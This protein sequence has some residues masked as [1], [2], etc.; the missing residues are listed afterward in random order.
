MAFRHLFLAL[1]LPSLA[2]SCSPVANVT[3]VAN[4]TTTDVRGEIR[5]ATDLL[6]APDGDVV[7]LPDAP[8]NSD[9]SSDLIADARVDA[10]ADADLELA[11][12]PS[13]DQEQPDAVTEDVEL[14]DVFSLDQEQPDALTEDVES[15]DTTTDDLESNDLPCA[16]DCIGKDCGDDGCEGSCGECDDGFLCDAGQCVEVS[17]VPD[18]AGKQC[19]DDGCEDSCGDCPPGDIC[20]MGGCLPATCAGIQCGDDG[21]GNSCGECQ[22]YCV[23]GLCHEGAGCE[24]GGEPG[25][26]DCGCQDCVCANDEFCC[27]SSWDVVCVNH[28]ISL[29]GGCAAMDNCGDGECTGYESCGNCQA[30]CGCQDGSI[31][32][33]NTCCELQCD[34]KS[35][36]D[37]GCGGTCGE[38]AIEE[39]CIWGVCLGPLIGAGC[40]P[41][42]F[43]S[44][45]CKSCDCE[46][47]VIDQDPG[48]NWKWDL[49]CV[50]RCIECGSCLETSCGNQLCEPGENCGSCPGDCPCQSGL[51]C[52]DQ[53][54][55]DC[56]TECATTECGEGMCGGD[57]GDCEAESPWCHAGKCWEQCKPNCNQ[58][59]CGDDGCG[60]SCGEC[61]AMQ[62]C[63]DGACVCKPTCEGVICGADSCGGSCGSCP[64][65]TACL[66]GDCIECEPD[67]AGLVC[68]DD[69][70]GG[71]CGECPSGY[72][73]EAGNCVCFME[74]G[75]QCC[76]WGE[77]C[78]DGS[79]CDDC[80]DCPCPEEGYWL[81]TMGECLCVEECGD[82]CCEYGESCGV[83]GTCCT[84]FQGASECGFDACTGEDYG[85]CPNNFQC[86][87]MNE[88]EWWCL[89]QGGR[90]LCGDTCCWWGQVCFDGECCTPHCLEDGCGDDGCGGSCGE[91]DEGMNC[92][93]GGCAPD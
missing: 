85:E 37:N 2:A 14:D 58:M 72:D 84:P 48:C 27:D 75:E 47:C 19:G 9:D 93:L 92:F 67:C 59:E 66:G 43:P 69:G 34:G 73:C 16:S 83:N 3:D 65:G 88:D 17:C 13:L 1:V 28:C 68:G 80:V 30:D 45:G 7:E 86:D 50:A 21:L 15:A 82:K 62:V 22:G 6:P 42:D 76:A 8:A 77:D 60:G 29:C 11:D 78:V 49:D 89:C 38:C 55:T 54:C 51:D 61:P 71:S 18:C 46:E 24:V 40:I 90:V 41:T 87:W 91:C 10:I 36:G 26:D 44:W 32:G 52:V 35:C 33:K 4:A 25:C 70:C 63:S 20:Q 79:Y 12:I 81:D 39:E 64:D 53:S 5:T 74:C 23:A 56:S 57:C 31:C